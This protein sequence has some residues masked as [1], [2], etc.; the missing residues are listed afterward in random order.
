MNKYRTEHKCQ[1]KSETNYKNLCNIMIV[2]LDQAYKEMDIPSAMNVLIFS[3]N[4]YIEN[5]D[6]SSKT[7]L[8][9][10]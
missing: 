4:F 9:K 8:S 10:T 7:S 6:L 1:L 2:I 5:A 3:N